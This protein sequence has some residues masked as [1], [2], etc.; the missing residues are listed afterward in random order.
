MMTPDDRVKSHVFDFCIAGG[1]VLLRLDGTYCNGL[2]MPYG[3]DTRLALRLGIELSPRMRIATS[4]A[5]IEAT[6]AFGHSEHR[7]TIPW[8]AVFDIAGERHDAMR[9]VWPHPPAREAVAPAPA[10]STLR[11][12]D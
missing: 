10:R 4:E 1:S 2:P 9:A 6:I 5:G 7:V 8:A 3:A 11:L 12:V